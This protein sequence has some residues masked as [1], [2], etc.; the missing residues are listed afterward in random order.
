MHLELE[1]RVDS[2]RILTGLWLLKEPASA[3]QQLMPCSLFVN[4][5]IY[6]MTFGSTA[7]HWPNTSTTPLVAHV[8]PPTSIAIWHRRHSHRRPSC[9]ESPDRGHFA[10]LDI[11]KNADSSHRGPPSQDFRGSFCGTLPLNLQIEFETDFWNVIHVY[12]LPKLMRKQFMLC[13]PYVVSEQ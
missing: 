10:S 2:N 12:L 1:F 4:L 11:E 6:A 8:A 9:S 5:A 3:P 7:P 13:N